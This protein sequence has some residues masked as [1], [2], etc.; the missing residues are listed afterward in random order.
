MSLNE[1][2]DGR[3]VTRLISRINGT[4]ESASDYEAT[5]PSDVVTPG[6]W[7]LLLSFANAHR[8]IFDVEFADVPEN[9]TADNRG[10][11]SRAQL[12]RM[13]IPKFNR[14]LEQYNLVGLPNREACVNAILAAQGAKG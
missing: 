4:V 9:N 10:N 14:L 2:F 13:S 7:E 5:T 8:E 11:F 1:F 12:E 3:T 6:K